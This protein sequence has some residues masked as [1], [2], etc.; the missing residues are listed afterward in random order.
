LQTA[1]Q[2]SQGIELTLP[3]DV[4]LTA[5]GFLQDYLGLTDATATCLGNGANVTASNDCLAERVN[6]RA[7]GLELLLR[8]DLTKRLTGWVSYTLS[9]STRETHGLIAPPVTPLLPPVQAGSSQD[10]LSEFDRTHVLNVIGAL[11]LGRGWRAGARFFFYTG[12]PYSPEVQG[13]PVPPFNS[14]RLPSFYRIDVR[15]EKRWPAF[16]SGSLALVIEGMNVTLAKEAID[17]TCRGDGTW[18]PLKYDSCQ[19]QYIG[20]V[21]VPSIGL[22][23][24]I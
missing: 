3:S 16:G 18:Y 6:G 15:L 20:P 1:L 11:D 24:A 13:V 10:I 8:R 4:T 19:P 23:G 22:E 7:F 5:T 2:A 17:V 14:L 21:S 9:R 12:R